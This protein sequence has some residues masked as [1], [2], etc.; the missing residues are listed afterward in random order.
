MGREQWLIMLLEPGFIC[1][2]ESVE[3]GRATL[4][5][6]GSGCATPRVGVTHRMRKRAN[7]D[8]VSMLHLKISESRTGLYAI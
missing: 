5:Y 2:Q 6:L 8:I 1:E 7:C 4:K 3:P